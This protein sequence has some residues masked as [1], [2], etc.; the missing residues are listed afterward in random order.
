[1]TKY[2]GYMGK[3]ALIDLSTEEISEYPWSDTERELFIGGKIMG[4]KILYDNL[5][6]TENAFSEENLVVITTGPL[7]GTPAPSTS[8]FN[9]SSLSPQT[10][11][12]ASSNCGGTFGYYLKKAGYDALV[13]KGKCRER[14]WIEIEN[15]R[16]EF[17]NADD[18]WGQMITPTQEMLQD[19]LEREHGY[20]V[21]CGKLCIGPAAENLVKY[22][23]IFSDERAAGRA[24]LGSVLG[25]KNLKAITVTGNKNAPVKSL[26]KSKKLNQKW[27]KALLDNPLTG[28]SL[29]KMG[30]AALLAPMQANSILSTKNYKYGQY[31]EYDKIS[32]EYLAENYNIVNKGCLSCP[33]KCARTVLVDGKEVK[34][35]ELEILGLFGSGIL[36]DDIELIFKWN[37]VIDEL[38]MDTISAANTVA[39]AMEANEKGLWNNG[40][41]FGKTDNITKTLED[42][43]Y[44]RGI[45]DD[46]AEG[47]RWCSEKYGGGEFAMQSKGLELSAYEPR[48]AVGQGLGYAISNRGACHLNGGYLVLFEGLGLHM[49]SQTP[50]AKADLVMM[51]QNIIEAVSASGHCLFT[52]Y[53]VL[54]KVLMENPNSALTQTVNKLLP[55]LGPI[56]R[57]INKHPELL[58]FDLPTLRTLKA[59]KYNVGMKMNLGKFIR[60]GER[61]YTMERAVNCR[62]GLTGEQDKLPDRLTKEPQDPSNPKTV[63]P[64]DKM[65]ADYYAARGWD[66]NGVP[67]EKI[68]RKLKIKK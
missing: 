31:N 59:Y 40:L 14:T 56:L 28:Q 51:F 50:K 21:K 63:V 4:A 41:E 35:P 36:N 48:R 5:K 11:I 30:T 39:W 55:K 43:A 32:G 68:L 18:L 7:T 67:T 57:F 60:I 15:D 65:K 3:V 1:M 66:K 19:K 27:V 61:G 52:S 42:I 12:T 8:R 25:W 44:R 34:G 16:I 45:G 62:F 64:L 53:I 6:G 20:R 23:G 13:I 24:G 17:H 54:P 9:I 47:S 33:M 46:L 22:A 49:D 29:P 58:A 2:T 10:G 37:H 38:G 26:A